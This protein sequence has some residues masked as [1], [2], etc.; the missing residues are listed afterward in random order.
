[1]KWSWKLGCFAGIDVYV[2]ATFFLLIGWVMLSHW[3]VSRNLAAALA[4]VA[5][6]LAIFLCVLLH[7]F[8]HSLA[9]RKYGIRT[10][11]IT[12]LPIGGVAHLERMPDNPWHELWVALAGPTVNVVIAVF[13][14]FVHVAQADLYPLERLTVTAGPFLQRLMMVNVFLVG[15]NMLPAFPMDGGRVV[16]ALLATRLEYTRATQIAAALGQAMALLFGFWGLF[17]NPF[18]LFIAFFVWIGA[19]AEASMAQIR[20]ALGGIPVA[21]AM[22][23]NY[24][25]VTPGEPLSRVVER[26]LAGSQQDFP[27]VEDGHVVGVLP[28]HD[29]LLALAKH[30]QDATVSDVMR[31]DFQLVDP[32]EMLDAVFTRLQECDCHTMPVVRGNQLV[33]LLTSDNVGEFMMIQSA[34]GGGRFRPSADLFPHSGPAA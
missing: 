28:R 10:R 2:H 25:A 33:G 32:G 8:G 24:E 1:M 16:R 23:T 26:I 34:L 22:L 11:Q 13:L 7:E 12:L 15:F 17:S 30:G 6:V 27:V 31:R 20:S 3:L 14:L 4:G 19:A 9:A 29:L 5:F 18:L 21:R